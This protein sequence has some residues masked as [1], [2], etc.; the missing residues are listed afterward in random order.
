VLKVAMMGGAQ[1]LTM[2]KRKS[3]KV[4][5]PKKKRVKTLL[6]IPFKTKLPKYGFAL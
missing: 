5:P 3:K 4:T 1:T 2:G 6:Q